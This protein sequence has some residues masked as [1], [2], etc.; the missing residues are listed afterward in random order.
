VTFQ[1]LTDVSPSASVISSAKIKL[2]S[3][4]SVQKQALVQAFN[5]HPRTSLTA[6]EYSAHV[7]TTLA[8][9]SYNYY[10]DDRLKVAGG[11][12]LGT[13]DFYCVHYYT[14]AG[15]QFSPFLYPASHWG[16]TKPIVVGE[17]YTAAT[18]GV[19]DVNLFSN[20]Y[21]NGYA[22][23]MAW[24]WTD[25]GALSSMAD[26]WINLKYMFDNHRDDI[27]T[28]PVIGT[29]Y[30]FAARN[31]TIEKTDST[32]VRW[33]VEPGSAVQFNGSTVTVKD[34][35]KVS[36]VT[37]TTYTLVANG[38]IT[39]TNTVT[40]TVLPY[41][42]IVSFAA[43]PTM[44]GTGE[45]TTLKWHVVKGSTVT[46]NDSAV[47]V[48]DTLVVYPTVS[49]NSYTLRTQGDVA[50][51]S[52][53]TISVGSP[54]QVDRAYGVTVTASSND[55]ASYKYSN[56]KYI[57][58]ENDY[59]RWQSTTTKSQTVL[60]DLGMVDTIKTIVITWGNKAYAKAYSIDVSTD[61]STW[62]VIK[63]IYSGTGGTNYTETFSNLSS[64][65]R[66]IDLLLQTP[67][68]LGYYSIAGVSVYGR[69]TLVTDIESSPQGVPTGYSLS[70]NYPNPFN[71][72]TTI[73]FTLKNSSMVKLTIYNILGQKIAT[74]VDGQRSAGYYSVPFNGSR[75]ASGVYFYRLETHEFQEEKKM[76][77]IK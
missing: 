47:K 19:S 26:T 11:D 53:V 56:P 12:S 13:L 1:T 40:V 49:S 64:V 22:G 57:V 74:L 30:V 29:I 62:S 48:V 9:T 18:D 7:A 27:I 51:S 43:S 35:I 70:Q 59:S 54:D 38:T 39:D 41:G 34:S 45:S 23:A 71:P 21:S 37:T 3:M 20:L 63:T 24:S 68:T 25:F 60:L 66:Y 58:D 50:D 77:L 67:G 36:P 65:G 61:N 69:P 6:E 72:S 8:S 52:T 73:K 76:L 14:D 75:Y 28:N 2:L 17:F 55:T 15:S 44:I 32:Y 31:S 4:S 5:L 46:L 16:L 33:D 42:R 10:Q